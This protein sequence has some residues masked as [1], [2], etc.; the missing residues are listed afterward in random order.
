MT[1]IDVI[2]TPDS[3][4]DGIE[5]WAYAPRYVQ[6][7]G[8]DSGDGDLPAMRMAYVDEGPRDAPA[9]LLLHGEPTWGYLYRHMVPPLLEAGFRVVVPDLVG[10]GRSDKPT[11]VEDYTY[12]RHAGWLTDLL[13]QVGLPED[14]TLFC[15]DWGSFLGLR[16]AG[17]QPRRFARIMVSNG[18][19]PAAQTAMGRGFGFW[20]FSARWSPFLPASVVIQIATRRRLS[21]AEMKAYEAPF[22]SRKAAAGVRAFPRLVPTE[23]DDPAMP[24]QQRAWDGL[25]SYDRPFLCVFGEH[26]FVLGSLDAPLIEHVPGAAAQPHD[27]IPGHHF[28][29]E[30]QGPE[31]AQRLVTFIRENPAD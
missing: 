11:R 22:G 10:F 9:V 26:D 17:L 2:R 25:G 27:R 15:Q 13:D 30:D 1:G 14:T 8:P 6:V 16:I 28:I 24:E 12:A 5:G 23:P 29:Q 18:F 21:V 19:L 4:L 3:R 7:G 20:R 31:L